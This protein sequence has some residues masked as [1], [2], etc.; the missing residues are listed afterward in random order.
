MWRVEFGLYAG[1]VVSWFSRTQHCVTLS[2]TESEYIALTEVTREVIFLRQ[3]LDFI[4][5]RREVRPVTIFED[6]DGAIKLADNPICTNRTKHIDVRYHFVREKVAN[7][8]VKVV[9][10][11]SEKQAADGLTKNLPEAALVRHRKT[12]LNE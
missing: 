3:I 2:T 1:S 4:E 9:H 11:E 12:L 8:T 7:Q 6:N 10:V 5:P